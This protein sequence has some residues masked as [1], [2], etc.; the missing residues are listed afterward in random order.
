MSERIKVL[1]VDDEERFLES[2]GKLLTKKGFDVIMASTGEEAIKKMSNFPDVVVLDVKMPGMDG[3]LALRAIKT[4]RP[5]I[6]IIMLTGH[7]RRPSLTIAMDEGAF[8]YLTKP[9]DVSLLASKIS[10]AYRCA[11]Q[12]T[13]KN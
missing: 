4:M 8:D 9:C 2:T 3:H 13:K 6:P 12:E 7:G 10:E 1:M 5:D 11:K